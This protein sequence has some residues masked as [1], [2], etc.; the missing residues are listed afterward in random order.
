MDIFFFCWLFRATPA[1]YWVESELQLLAYATATAMWDLNT[2]CNL[3]HSSWQCQILHPLSK[4]ESRTH[5]LVDISRVRS[6]LNLSGN[7]R[8]ILFYTAYTKNKWQYI[9]VA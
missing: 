4:A 9:S 1:A 5:I 7:S 6:P 2:T 8:Y 3:H